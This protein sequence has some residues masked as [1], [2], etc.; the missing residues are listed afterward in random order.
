MKHQYI[1]GALFR[2]LLSI[3]KLEN[4]VEYNEKLI[5]HAIH[6]QLDL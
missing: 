3:K 4:K 5:I 2:I 1:N 6:A